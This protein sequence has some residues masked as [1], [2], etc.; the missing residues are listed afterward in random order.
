M[1]SSDGGGVG[2]LSRSDRGLELRDEGRLDSGDE[3]AYEAE[4]DDMVSGKSVRGI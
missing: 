1:A 4:E 2:E 3:D